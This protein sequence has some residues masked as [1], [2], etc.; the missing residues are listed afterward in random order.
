MEEITK[1]SKLIFS[2]MIARRLLKMG[3]Q[4]IDIKADH[5]DSKRTV[6]VFNKDEK[7]EQNFNTILND[8]ADEKYHKKNKN[9]TVE[10]DKE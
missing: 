4:I 1:N 2:P 9:K 10:K 3:S 7:F 5:T 8:I 6:F